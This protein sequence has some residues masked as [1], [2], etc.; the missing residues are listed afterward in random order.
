VSAADTALVVQRFAVVVARFRH[1]PQVLLALPLHLLLCHRH[2]HRPPPPY[3]TWCGLKPT[4]VV[5]NDPGTASLQIWQ[6]HVKL[7]EEGPCA[8]KDTEPHVQLP[9]RVDAMPV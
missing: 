2:D 7:K 8:V 9:L 6:W 4:L 1:Q 3:S 5:V